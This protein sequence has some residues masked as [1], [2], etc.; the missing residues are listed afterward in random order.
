VTPFDAAN[1]PG[2]FTEPATVFAWPHE[3]LDFLTAAVVPPA[4]VTVEPGPLARGDLEPQAYPLYARFDVVPGA[5]GEPAANF[6]DRLLLSEATATL[7]APDALTVAL[8]LA[9]SE[10]RPAAESLPHL[11]IHVIGPT[12]DGAEGVLAQYDGPP[13][14]GLWPQAGWQSLLTVG[15]RHT[16]ALPRPFDPATDR[17]EVG[18][19]DPATGR[20]LPLLDANG[21]PGDDKIVLRPGD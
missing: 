2:P 12:G 16:L 17:V 5:V 9:A 3:G 20:R 18:L 1:P 10:T 7:D 15:E 4:R 11:F 19:Y 14:F 6:D 13:A 8:A 21:T